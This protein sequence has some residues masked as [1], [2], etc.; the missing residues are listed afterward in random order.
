MIEDPVDSRFFRLG[1]PEGTFIAILDGSTSLR[2]AIRLTATSLGEDAFTED[3]ATAIVRWLMDCELAYPVTATAPKRSKK[4]QHGWNPLALQITLL[5]PDRIFDRLLPWIRWLFSRPMWIFWIVLV[6]AACWT[7]LS[8]PV[9][10]AADAGRGHR[11]RE[12]VV[13]VPD[14]G[15][16]E[17]RA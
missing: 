5:H 9:E 17:N 12:V 14:M 10:F 4:N 15:C 11:S 16:V 6:G 3:D 2:D 13:A 7:L 1:I 8:S